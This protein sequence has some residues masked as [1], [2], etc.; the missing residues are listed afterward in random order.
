MSKLPELINSKNYK[1]V[2]KPYKKEKNEDLK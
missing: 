2:L 1:V